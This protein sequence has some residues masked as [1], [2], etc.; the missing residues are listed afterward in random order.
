VRYLHNIREKKSK[1]M[2]WWIE[3]A[4]WDAKLIRR[5][6]NGNVEADV[7]SRNPALPTENEINLNTDGGE[8]QHCPV[9]SIFR[10]LPW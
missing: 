10:Q 6:G 4:S 3:I 1:L 9:F 7:C 2:R 8:V 5:F